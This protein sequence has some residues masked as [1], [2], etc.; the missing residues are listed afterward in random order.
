MNEPTK[1][2]APQQEAFVR[3]RDFLRR[4]STIQEIQQVAA[5]HLNPERLLDLV[6][7]H[8]RR[9]D[10][11]LRCTPESLL[12]CVIRCARLGIEPTGA[13]GG[14]YIIPFK[15]KK[16]VNGRWIDIYVATPITDYRAEIDLAARTGLCEAIEP[17]IIYDGDT[18]E[19]EEG[20]HPR[21]VHKPGANYQAEGQEVLVYARGLL[22]S[23]KY[24]AEVLYKR[25]IERRRKMSRS[26][27]HEKA[28][29]KTH[30]WRMALK[31]AV[32]ALTNR[33]PKSS[34]FFESSLAQAWGAHSLRETVADLG[35]EEEL[36]EIID[37]GGD[38]PPDALPTS[39]TDVVA[40][41]LRHH[42]AS[43]LKAWEKEQA[44]LADEAAKKGG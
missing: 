21:L 26:G 18:W 43:D 4:K 40:T 3:I 41:K 29:W 31:S 24:T 8:T 9:S 1:A 6:L 38:P 14:M 17:R 27:D 28:P 37:V 22:P 35:S 15:A 25:E 30:Y 10:L 36:G 34:K 44:R 13:A 42:A 12:E 7:S 5:A 32:R 20:D 16:Q 39:S 11:L 2:L 19:H 23:G 33:L